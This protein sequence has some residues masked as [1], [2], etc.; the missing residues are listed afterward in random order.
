MNKKAREK[1]QKEIRGAKFVAIISDDTTDVSS[2]MQNVVVLR[3][4]VSGKIEEKFGI[5]P[6]YLKGMLR[7]YQ[8]TCLIA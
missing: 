6:I 4:V 7:R 8:Q 2:F 1:I 3:Y 5:L